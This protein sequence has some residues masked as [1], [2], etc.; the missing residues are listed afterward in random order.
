M[1][2]HPCICKFADLSPRLDWLVQN[3][4]AGVHIPCSADIPASFHGL[5][6]ASWA[7]FFCDLLL[8]MPLENVRKDAA[9]VIL[10]CAFIWLYPPDPHLKLLDIAIGQ[11]KAS[12]R[13][14]S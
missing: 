1:A 14:L 9:A 12:P 8:V 4:Q 11:S 2:F 7:L 13:A 3:Q 6:V 10:D 5:S